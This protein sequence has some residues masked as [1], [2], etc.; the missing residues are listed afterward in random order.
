[1][2]DFEDIF[3]R[4]AE[5]KNENGQ[6]IDE[7]AKELAQAHNWKE[8]DILH[9]AFDN[10]AWFVNHFFKNKDF[11]KKFTA[12]HQELSL[13]TNQLKGLK[14]KTND[15]TSSVYLKLDSKYPIFIALMPV[16]LAV[17][18]GSTNSSKPDTD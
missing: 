7:C 5:L 12:Y 2:S 15:I 9:N 14:V 10:E 1:M 18:V 3:T 6:T 8:K 17:V 16:L 13:K 11:A 4:F